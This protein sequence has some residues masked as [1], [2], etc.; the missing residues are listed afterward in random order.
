M[1]SISTQ[2]RLFL[3]EG[4]VNMQKSFEGLSA[5]VEHAFPGELMKGYFIFLNRSRDRMKVLYWDG[6]GFSIW[7]K[8]LEKGSF[9]RQK[10]GSAQ[11]QRR[12]FFMLLE[13]VTPK[14][15]QR[16]FSLK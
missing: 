8:R 1:I 3:F 6:D 7:Y 5:L 12:E 9:L 14:K 13:G 4:P 10:K 2:A 11:L 16:R 15:I